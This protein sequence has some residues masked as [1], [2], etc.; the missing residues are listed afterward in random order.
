MNGS[1]D[2]KVLDGFALTGSRK[3]AART[4]PDH[5]S[6]GYANVLV[7]ALTKQ[8]VERGDMA[9]LHVKDGN[10]GAA[11]VYEKLGFSVR[12]VRDIATLKKVEEM[13]A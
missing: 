13:H 2:A 6:K 8:I 3:S 4:H 10:S 5:R 9:F 1:L 7:A 11:K 12:A